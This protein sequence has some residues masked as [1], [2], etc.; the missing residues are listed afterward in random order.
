[1]VVG[2]LSHTAEAAMSVGT[3]S[4]YCLNSK[5]VGGYS[6][7]PLPKQQKCPGTQ[8]PEKVLSLCLV[9]RG[10]VLDEK[11]VHLLYNLGIPR[12]NSN[13]HLFT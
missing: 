5:D 10:A 9:Y 7:P 8:L 1:M 3:L 12:Q 6:L 11:L 2:T 13:L 4:H